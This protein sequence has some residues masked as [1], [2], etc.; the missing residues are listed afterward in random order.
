MTAAALSLL[1]GQTGKDVVAVTE[2]GGDEHELILVTSQEP[3]I[4]GLREALRYRTTEPRTGDHVWLSRPWDDDHERPALSIRVVRGHAASLSQAIIYST[5]AHFLQ[6]P[7]S[8]QELLSAIKNLLL[9][10]DKTTWA[11]VL[12]HLAHR[13][14]DPLAELVSRYIDG[15]CQFSHAPVV[16][17]DVEQETPNTSTIR[18]PRLPVMQDESNN[19]LRSFLRLIQ[20]DG[21]GDE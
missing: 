8:D 6:T 14:D 13:G 5:G 9:L 3:Y 12:R 20:G 2:V 11:G 10:S 15:G 16:I 19:K 7:E 21:K 4:C 18:Q 17:P 1:G